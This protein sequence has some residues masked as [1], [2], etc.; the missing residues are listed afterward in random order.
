MQII[1]KYQ[2]TTVLVVPYMIAELLQSKNLKKFL[3][4][5]NF[6]TGGTLI[7][8]S[9]MEK[10][11]TFLPNGKIFHIYGSTEVA[12]IVAISINSSENVG[13]LTHNIEVKV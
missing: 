12:N 4:V 2:M 11:Q 5:K 10:L 7:G 1:E 13:Q 9:L 8:K 6:A 3:S